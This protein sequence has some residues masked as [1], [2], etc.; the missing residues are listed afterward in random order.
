[1]QVSIEDAYQQALLCLGELTVRERLLQAQLV[2]RTEELT[3]AL[4]NSLT[5]NPAGATHE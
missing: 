5:D 2:R 4:S 1:M 3:T